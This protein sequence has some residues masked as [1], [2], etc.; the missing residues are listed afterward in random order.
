M[1]GQGERNDRRM[2]SAKQKF[3]VS[4]ENG[5]D[6][7]SSLFPLF[8]LTLF[9]SKNFEITRTAPIARNFEISKKGNNRKII[10]VRKTCP[11]D[12]DQGDFSSS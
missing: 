9:T 3:S 2:E 10:H 8:P 1:L 5:F 7:F 4:N 12:H 6:N 11:Q